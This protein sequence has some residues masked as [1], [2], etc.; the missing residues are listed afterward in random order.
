MYKYQN[1][2]WYNISSFLLNQ[3]IKNAERQ[4]NP[5]SLSIARNPTHYRDNRTLL[6]VFSSRQRCELRCRLYKPV[7]SMLR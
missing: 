6:Q 3:T 4:S 2:V 5:N 7:H 1:I